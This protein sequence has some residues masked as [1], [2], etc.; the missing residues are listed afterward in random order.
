VLLAQLAFPVKKPLFY[1]Y[2]FRSCDR[3]QIDALQ[4]PVKHFY[5]LFKRLFLF[6]VNAA[7][8]GGKE[9]ERDGDRDGDEESKSNKLSFSFP[10]S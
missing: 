9:N 1:L 7:E 2:V 10:L 5:I 4:L 6:S 8:D 3:A